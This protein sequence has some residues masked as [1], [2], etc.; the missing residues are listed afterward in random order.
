LFLIPST[1]LCALALQSDLAIQQITHDPAA[2][3]SGGTVTFTVTIKNLGAVSTLVPFTVGFW[4]NLTSAPSTASVPE[5]TQTAQ[6]LNAGDSVQLTFS[7]VAP[8]AGTYS[9]WAYADQAGTV[10]D[11]DR[12]NNVGLLPSGHGWQVT[13]PLSTPGPSGGFNQPGS[14]AQLLFTSPPSEMP[15]PAVAGSEVR[16]SVAA[17]SSNGGSLTYAWD[18][19]DAVSGT[20]DSTT[21]VYAAAGVFT[22]VLTVSNGTQSITGTLSVAVNPQPTNV[23]SNTTIAFAVKKAGLKINTKAQRKDM[24]SLSGVLPVQDFSP[25]GKDVTV[26]V[27]KMKMDYLLNSKATGGSKNDTFKLSGKLSGGKY[28][29]PTVKFQLVLKN[30]ELAAPLTNFMFPGIQDNSIVNLPVVISTDGAV[31][32]VDVVHFSYNTKTGVGT[33]FGTR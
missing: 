1:G 30:Q 8:V 19:G 31:W 3:V 14:S 2:P 10:L 32:Q 17:T 12:N 11:S 26:I 13:Q 16:F 24:L 6:A 27:G 20:G 25:T 15:N 4:S 29:T 33:L 28:V 9:A 5:Q 7:L 18:F 23:N 22:V 21:H